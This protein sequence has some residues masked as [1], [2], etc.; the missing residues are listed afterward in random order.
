MAFI[1]LKN[2]Q[3]K[4][5]SAE[6]GATIWRVKNGEIKGTKAQQAFVKNISK[7]YLNRQNAPKSYIAANPTTQKKKAINYQPALPY[8]D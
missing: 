6:Q 2:H 4:F 1:L 3:T 5:V 8:K 7:I